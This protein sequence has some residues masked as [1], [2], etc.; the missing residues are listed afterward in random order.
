[1]Q[2]DYI[3]KCRKCNHNLYVDKKETDK[4]ES[5]P[6]Y[7]CPNCGEDGYENWVFIGSGNYDEEYG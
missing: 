6:E 4:I 7:D 5:M 3:F 2:P 1:M